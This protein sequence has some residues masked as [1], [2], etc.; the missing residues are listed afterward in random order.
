M[1][2]V[3]TP[4]YNRAYCLNKC[5]ESLKRQTCKDFIWLVI[6]DGSTDNT[7]DLVEG[8]I[9]EE[10][11]TIK[12]IY[13]SNQG[14]HGAHNTAYEH[15]DT[16]LNVC[17]D[18]DDYMTDDAVQKILSFW[19]RNKSEDLA[20]IAGLDA[21]S[22][23]NIIGSPF[24]EHLL[25][26][27]LF[28]LNNKYR[29]K[30]DKKL[31]YRTDLTKKYIYPI[32]PNEKYVGLAYKYYQI[33]NSHR[34]ALVNEVLCI[35]EYQKD[36]SS[37]NM[38]QQYRKNPRGFAFY[39]LEN[40]KNPHAGLPFKL[41]EYIHYVSSSLIMGNRNFLKE[42]P[43]KILALLAIPGGYLLYRYIMKNTTTNQVN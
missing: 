37:M 36:G 17:I 39:R 2:T 34:L 40:I 4:T 19:M 18:S 23:G 9:S 10:A 21:T 20:G 27:T 41:K 35:V 24:P 6:D 31:V 3:F 5:Y 43:N 1:L 32:F 26:A 28:D 42:C 16:E 22:D 15:I 33:D 7:R 30:G 38:L 13:Q 11:I 8:W 29:I 25:K 12:Y 14:M